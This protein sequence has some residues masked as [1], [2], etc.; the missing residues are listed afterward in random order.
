MKLRPVVA[1]LVVAGLI[2]SPVIATAKNLHKHHKSGTTKSRPVKGKYAAYTGLVVQNNA[3]SPVSSFDWTD[4]FHLSGYVNVDARYASRGP[5]GIVPQF[6]MSDDAHELN[7]N[8]ANVFVDVDVSKCVTAHVGFAYVAD[9]VN[10]FDLGLHTL[11]GFTPL[12]ESVRSDKGSVFAGGEVSMDEAY[13]TISN[14]ACSPLFFRAGKMYIPF[15]TYSN[16]YPIT[17]S[18]PQL[19]SQT[20]G[21]A[22]E[23]GF[24]SSCGLYGTAYVLDGSQSS[25]SYSEEGFL[26]NKKL[27]GYGTHTNERF[28][29]HIPYTRINNYGV[30]VGYQGSFRCIDFHANAAYIKDI[31]DVSYLADIQ[32]L[33]A[34]SFTSVGKVDDATPVSGPK[35]FGMRSSGG[36]SAHVDATYGPMDFNFDYVGALNNV[37]RHYENQ[38]SQSDTRV[39][40]ADVA[41]TYHTSVCGYNTAVSLSYQFSRQTAGIMPK[42]RYQGDVSVEI[43]H[44][45]NLTFEYRHDRDYEKG[46]DD[47]F[48]NY[49]NYLETGED[50]DNVVCGGTGHTSN[51]AT[52][53][54]GVVF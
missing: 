39:W 43:F 32:D 13:I 50:Y 49:I 16:P 3:K 45:T 54:L 35:G 40:A 10:L 7:V 9:S 25:Q 36:V 5:L 30:K 21:T 26:H 51:Q 47:N 29:D 20:R 24:V 34:F 15:G 53:R 2:S 52:L 4:R 11:S 33:M 6:T 23:V 27:E 12:T 44:N 17:Y 48:C 31:R 8:N 1:S 22:A 41:G 28:G 46:S 18:L 37:V 14:F 42:W 38:T 19:L